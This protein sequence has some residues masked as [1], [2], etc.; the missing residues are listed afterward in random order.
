M[1]IE[2]I[3]VS[4]AVLYPWIFITVLT[5]IGWIYKIADKVIQCN[6]QKKYISA[7]ELKFCKEEQGE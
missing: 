3:E 6:M 7:Y 1:I 2:T 5:I 4:K